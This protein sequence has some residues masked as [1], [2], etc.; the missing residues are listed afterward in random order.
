M[1][2]N[3]KSFILYA[4]Q[5]TIFDS[6][7]DKEAGVLIKHIYSYVNDENPKAVTKLLK[8]AFEPI[9]QQLKRDLKDWEEKK[10]KRAEA[11][12]E[13]GLASGKARLKQTEATVPF[14][15]KKEANEAVNGIGNVNGF[16]S[17]IENTATPPQ[18]LDSIVLYDAEQEILTKQPIWFEQLCMR[19]GKGL[20]DGKRILREFHLYKIEKEHYPMSKDQALAGFERWMG[21]EKKFNG[22]GKKAEEQL[23]G[24]KL[25]S[26]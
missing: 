20:Q 17:E 16:V 19:M 18:I 1:A 21:N 23:I 6:L 12:R 5:K 26:I 8:V 24:P 10:A 4:D 15:S 7:S 13:G 2:Q 9:K 25:T 3:K 14:A 22:A 11:G